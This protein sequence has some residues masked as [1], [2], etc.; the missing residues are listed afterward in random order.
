[1]AKGRD[2]GADNAAIMRVLPHPDAPLY[3]LDEDQRRT[4]NSFTAMLAQ[5][6]TYAMLDILEDALHDAQD[7]TM[8]EDYFGADE[9]A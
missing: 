9:T 4:F 7:K 6:D 3:T 8:F 5:F 1:M 2:A